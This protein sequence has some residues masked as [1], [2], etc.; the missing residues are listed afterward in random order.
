MIELLSIVADPN[1]AIVI[2]MTMR[3]P[4]KLSGWKR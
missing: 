1:A 3:H 4:E 2:T